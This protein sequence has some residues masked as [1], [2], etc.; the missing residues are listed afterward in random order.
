MKFEGLEAQGG[1]LCVYP[2]SEEIQPVLRHAALLTP[3]WKIVSL[4]SPR[5][6]GFTGQA[7]CCGGETLTVK[8]SFDGIPD[9]VDYILIPE[10]FG[11]LMEPSV[12]KRIL[13]R[14]S[15]LLSRLRGVL[16]SAVL[17]EV[18][19]E[20][21]K[22]ACHGV[23]EFI[24]LNSKSSD[25]SPVQ[26]YVRREGVLE[27]DVPVIGIMGMW[28]S[29]DKFEV[30]LALREKFI[31]NGYKV[32]QIGS[33][34]Y[35][36][37]MGFHSFPRFMLDP[38]EGEEDKI[39]KLNRYLKRLVDEE[40]PDVI[41]VTIPGGTQQLNNKFPNRFG[42]LPF[43]VSKAATF[44][45]LVLCTLYEPNAGELFELISTSFKYKYGCGADVFHMSNTIFD[46]ASISEKDAMRLNHIA[47]NDVKT[48]VEENYADL[49]APMV[50]V[51]DDEGAEKL[52]SAI[53][54]K[55]TENVADIIL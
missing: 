26:Q 1:N 7:I 28:D 53:V 19:Y 33:R 2:Y 39:Y 24:D 4:V 30:S 6:W 9:S 46:V 43:L 54:G 29:T 21:L 41:L 37:I 42:I 49:T 12:V 44:D 31:R 8:P 36:E 34:N 48:A 32:A 50:D 55:L 38:T 10:F 16:L 25:L 51:Y 35:C 11:S 22:S 14:V 13:S 17:D 23:C 15:P 18:N 20:M 47:R 52:Y 3:E 45:A 5:S 27:I 40:S